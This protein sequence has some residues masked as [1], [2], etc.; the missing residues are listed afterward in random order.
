MPDPPVDIQ[1]MLSKPSLAGSLHNY[2]NCLAMASVGG[3]FPE[4]GVNYR[5][6]GKLYHQIGSL[7]P[8]PQGQRPKFS[9]LYFHDAD[10]ELQNRLGYQSRAKLVPAVVTNLQELLRNTNPY[11]SSFKAALEMYG[12]TD[13]VKIVLFSTSKKKAD[14]QQVHPGCLS[15][16]QGCEVAFC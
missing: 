11:L 13:N 6:Q 14:A 4:Q 2:N 15:L 1:H 9:A 8:P 12:N 16:P 5:V 10:H 3:N 7:G